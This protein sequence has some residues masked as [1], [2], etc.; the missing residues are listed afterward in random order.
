MYNYFS[1]IEISTSNSLLKICNFSF[2]VSPPLLWNIFILMNEKIHDISFVYKPRRDN[3]RKK[4]KFLSIVKNFFYTN[5]IVCVVKLLDIYKLAIDINFYIPEFVYKKNSY[6][7]F[8]LR[9][10]NLSIILKFEK[11]PIP[12]QKT[13]I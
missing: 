4:Y 13:V 3:A 12:F 1:N 7:C 6:I 11:M 5:S 8:N 9:I 10:L 2:I